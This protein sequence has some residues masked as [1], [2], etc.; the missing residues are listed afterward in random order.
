[1]IIL[2]DADI[3]YYGGWRD[4]HIGQ[5]PVKLPITPYCI[6]GNHEMRSG[7]PPCYHTTEWN[8]GQVYGEDAYLNQL[9]CH[10]RRSVQPGRH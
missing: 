9:F 4:I 10:G 5:R 7:T 1:M 2:G 6:H 8:G 3:N